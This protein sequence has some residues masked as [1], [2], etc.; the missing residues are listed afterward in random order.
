MGALANKFAFAAGVA[1]VEF[2]VRT[3]WRG[4]GEAQLKKA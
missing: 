3:V 1:V 2:I 4:V